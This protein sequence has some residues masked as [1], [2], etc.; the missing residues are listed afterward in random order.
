M[1]EWLT[2][3]ELAERTN[4]TDSSIR[5]YISNFPDFFAHRGGQRG[6]RYEDSAVKVLARIKT[7]Y[8]ERFETA[9]VEAALKNEFPKIIDDDKPDDSENDP[10][11]AADE[12]VTSFKKTELDLTD[13]VKELEHAYKEDSHRRDQQ[14]MKV[15]REF[16]E[17][18]QIAAAT[19]PDEEQPAKKTGFWTR[20]FSKK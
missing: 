3:K 19:E 15:L 18:K 8:E 5:R 12:D 6:R 2:I 13:N 10:A 9:D 17:T 20:L 4:I 1:T 14:L 7:L 16:Q 11:F